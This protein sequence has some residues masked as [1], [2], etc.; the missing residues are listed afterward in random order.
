MARFLYVIVW[1][2]HWKQWS[3]LSW[4]EPCSLILFKAKAEE[5]K[6]LAQGV[7]SQEESDQDDEPK[8]NHQLNKQSKVKDKVERLGRLEW[9]L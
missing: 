6:L 1:Q 8:E 5:T 4:L 9:F 2:L 7:E 3:C